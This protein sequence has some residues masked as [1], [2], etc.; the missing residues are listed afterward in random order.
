MRARDPGRGWMCKSS[1]CKLPADRSVRRLFANSTAFAMP[2]LASAYATKNVRCSGGAMAR[3]P[4][5]AACLLALVL[6]LR[7]SPALAQIWP[8]GPVRIVV[9]YAAGGPVDFPARLLIDR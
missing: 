3:F 7:G 8:A 2:L 1:S 9:P 5:A 6:A 4:C